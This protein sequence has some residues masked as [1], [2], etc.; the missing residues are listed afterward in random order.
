MNLLVADGFEKEFFFVEE[1]ANEVADV[2]RWSICD[3]HVV[4]KGGGVLC[5]G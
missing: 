2:Q 5:L 3:A 4:R 1:R